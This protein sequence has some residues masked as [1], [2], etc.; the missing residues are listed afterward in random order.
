MDFAVDIH[1]GESYFVLEMIEGVAVDMIKL[2]SCSQI[3]ICVNFEWRSTHCYQ[4][5]PSMLLYSLQ[6]FSDTQHGR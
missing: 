4:P 3:D 5:E 2:Y 6:T 1:T